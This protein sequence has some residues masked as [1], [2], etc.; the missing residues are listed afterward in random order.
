MSDISEARR[1]RYKKEIEEAESKSAGRGNFFKIKKGVTSFRVLPGQEPGSIDKDFAVK[2]IQH[3][4]VIADSKR[5]ITCPKS[6]NDQ[7]YCPIHE[8]YEKLL[9]GD[10]EEQAEAKMIRPA[11][12][13]YIG[14]I[15]RDTEDEANF[16]KIG[17]LPV[18]ETVKTKIQK[19]MLNEDYD[20]ITDPTEGRDIKIE[21]TGEKIDTK[22]EVHVRPKVRPIADDEDAIKEI[23]DNQPDLWKYAVANTAE[24]IKA[25]MDGKIDRLP[26]PNRPVD[27]KKK[28]AKD[29]DGDDD[30]DTPKTAKKAAPAAK[31]KP[32][33][34]DDDDDDEEDE[35]PAKKTKPR[36]VKEEEEEE[37]EPKPKVKKKSVAKAEEEDEDDEEDEKP[38]PTS[39]KRKPV[40]KD[41]EDE[42]D[43]ED[44]PKPVKSSYKSVAEKIK[45]AKHARG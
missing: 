39:A 10:E 42:E 22:Y 3:F 28:A 24:E 1:A 44:E 26:D 34:D 13:W 7:A 23:L 21:K 32:A 37:E 17:I 20:D 30:D 6:S 29:E 40:V 41:E 27:A 18:P 14:V 43:E 35:K 33:A 9:K 36:L 38:V 19:I 25:F 5:P 45:A 4:N 31:K 15:N 11:R 8:R 16:N 2:V 12:R